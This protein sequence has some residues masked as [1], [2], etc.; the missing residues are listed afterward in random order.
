MHDL[1]VSFL[2]DDYRQPFFPSM[3][4][5]YRDFIQFA[6]KKND[7]YQI[8]TKISDVGRQIKDLSTGFGQDQE[9]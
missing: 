1:I 6:E 3:R 4:R 9:K 7:T 5:L 8:W 2:P